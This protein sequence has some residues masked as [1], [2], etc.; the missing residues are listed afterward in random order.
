MSETNWDQEKISE[1]FSTQRGEEYKEI[2]KNAYKNNLTYEE[3][4]LDLKV[5]TEK[6]SKKND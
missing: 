3:V 5:L 4:S 2:M 1:F 6:Y